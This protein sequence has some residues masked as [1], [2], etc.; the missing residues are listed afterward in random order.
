M[1]DFI[2][3]ADDLPIKTES[4]PNETD[5]LMTETQSSTTETTSLTVD[6]QPPATETVSA[7][8]ETESSSNTPVSLL[9]AT[10]YPDA[11]LWKNT[12]DRLPKPFVKWAGGKGQILF[13]LVSRMPDFK[14]TYFEPFVGGGALFFFLRPKK[15]VLQDSNEELIHLYTMVRQ[16]TESLIEA[17]SGLQYT[18][19]D[20]YR[21]RTED[22]AELEPLRRAARTVYLNRTGFNGLYRVNKSGKFNV[23]MGRYVN[24]TI[25]DEKNLRACAEALRDTK[26]LSESFE[27]VVSRS[28]SGDFVYFDPPYVPAS[29]TAY[30]TAYQSGGF[31]MADQ[32]KLLA[33]FRALTEKG[34]YAMLSNADVPWT[35]E[36]YGQF[37]VHVIKA[38]RNV[39]SKAEARGPVGELIVTNY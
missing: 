8:A 30:F 5:P 15:A 10:R 22:P 36:A 26:I 25:C 4:S 34:V 19:E 12:K 11:V 28:K 33:V 38:R 13:E 9:S 31:S 6:T 1:H 3:E 2:N 20:Y 24:P 23:P 37:K 39:N 7:S 35:R 16:E 29:K 32:E 21:I 17:L 18:K 27:T 14:G